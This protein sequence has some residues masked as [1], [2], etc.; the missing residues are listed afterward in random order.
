MWSTYEPVYPTVTPKTYCTDNND[1]GTWKLSKDS[2]HEHVQNYCVDNRKLPPPTVSNVAPIDLPERDKI[3]FDALNVQVTDPKTLAANEASIKSLV[4]SVNI[5]NDFPTL[6]TF[7][8]TLKPGASE[9]SALDASFFMQGCESMSVGELYCQKTDGYYHRHTVNFAEADNG[10]YFCGNE[11]I[12]TNRCSFSV[13]E[14]V[15]SQNPSFYAQQCEITDA[16]RNSTE[17]KNTLNKLGAKAACLQFGVMKN[18]NGNRTLFNTAVMQDRGYCKSLSPDGMTSCGEFPRTDVSLINGQSNKVREPE[19][20]KIEP[21]KEWILHMWRD[22]NYKD[23]YATFDSLNSRIVDQKISN[24]RSLRI[25]QT[26][27]TPFG[28]SS[29]RLDQLKG[30]FYVEFVSNKDG[31]THKG[32]GHSRL[33]NT[34]VDFYRIIET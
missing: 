12:K 18:A 19:P 30:S 34:D 6:A 23:N 10:I 3:K 25:W 16:V 21:Q 24:G 9:L 1:W 4:C 8:R 13:N 29:Y 15:S 31:V 22:N 14:F 5:L 26:D 32:T 11:G 20:K 7:C 27:K 17:W 2:V 28:T 33:G